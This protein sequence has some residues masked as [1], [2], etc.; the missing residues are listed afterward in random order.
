MQGAPEFWKLTF[1]ERNDTLV[2]QSTVNSYRSIKNKFSECR[3]F[4]VASRKCTNGSKIR[5]QK[6]FENVVA[7]QILW[8]PK[9]LLVPYFGS[10][11]VD[12]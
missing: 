10:P 1:K 6:S 8:S 9:E 4:E 7:R 2:I 3:F 12:E 5:G 11:T